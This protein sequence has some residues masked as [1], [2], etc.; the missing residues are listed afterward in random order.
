MATH[1][2]ALGTLSYR[3]ADGNS[4]TFP[5]DVKTEITSKHIK[6]GDG[7]GIKYVEHTLTVDGWLYAAD[8]VTSAGTVDAAFEFAKTVLSQSGGQLTI[9]NKGFGNHYI[10]RDSSYDRDVKFGP[11]PEMLQWEVIGNVTCKFVWQVTF[12][13]PWRWNAATSP[14]ILDLVWKVHYEY[15]AEGFCDRV[16]SGEME[17]AGSRSAPG[18]IY[19]LT[20]SF[21]EK[22]VFQNIVCSCPLGYHRLGHSIDI[23]ESKTKATFSVKD[24]ADRGLTYPP[25]ISDMDIVHDISTQ[26]GK[27]MTISNWVWVI[28]VT[29]TADARY[30]TR[31]AYSACLDAHSQRFNYMLRRI[32]DTRSGAMV[33]T[34]LQFKISENVKKRQASLTAAW[35]LTCTGSKEQGTFTPENLVLRTG[36]FQP[37]SYSPRD[38]KIDADSPLG[39]NRTGGYSQL[40][41]DQN[42]NAIVEV[43]NSYPAVP[44]MGKAVAN[45]PRPAVRDIDF[46]V[47]APFGLYL[48]FRA[49][50]HCKIKGNQWVTYPLVSP[51]GQG[52]WATG[53]ADLAQDIGSY[54]E[55]M[56][57][58]RIV[59]VGIPPQ[60]VPTFDKIG[61]LSVKIP[62]GKEATVITRPFMTLPGYLAW[63]TRF[64]IPLIAV[65]KDD[66]NSVKAADFDP[67]YGGIKQVPRA[68]YGKDDSLL[69]LPD[70][71]NLIDPPR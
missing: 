68:D 1:A 64:W 10:N 41:P 50:V 35:L 47:Q 24:E 67:T 6:T 63:E 66:G 20:T 39:P 12:T 71:V 65:T 45:I 4:V 70:N 34:P 25:G 69:N 48:D 60:K 29:A 17:I 11:H 2:P 40:Y 23:D 52:A 62:S 33:P 28:S 38:H 36:I 44:D 58:G 19:P 57:V 13:L 30:P 9:V 3:S 37:F 5:G 18:S 32:I 54:N 31:Y 7:R 16:I 14:G 27:E 51:K 42:Q 59:R 55:Y 15:D 26:A 21:V 22:Y 61:R 49:E 56:V 8:L 43:S 53:R 46:E